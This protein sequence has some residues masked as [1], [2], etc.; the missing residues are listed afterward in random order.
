MKNSKWQHTQHQC[1][2]VLEIH[3]QLNNEVSRQAQPTSLRPVQLREACEEPTSWV[4][5]VSFQG[6]V[7]KASAPILNSSQ[8]QSLAGHF[9]LHL[10]CLHFIF[11]HVNLDYFTLRKCINSV[12]CLKSFQE[13]GGI[14][15][16]STLT[17]LEG[18]QQRKPRHQ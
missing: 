4:D 5:L 13:Q 10:Y 3:F 17:S 6:E 7:L 1:A 11:S 12:S 16:T 18:K 8:T 15:V 14:Y 2:K 9:T